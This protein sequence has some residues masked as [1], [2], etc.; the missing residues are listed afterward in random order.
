VPQFRPERPPVVTCW[1]DYYD[2]F[3]AHLAQFYFWVEYWEKRK[4]ASGQRTE[5]ACL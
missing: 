5:G 1:L 4:Q 3:C 2:R